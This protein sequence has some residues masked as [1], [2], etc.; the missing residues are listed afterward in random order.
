PLD[1]PNPLFLE[2][3]MRKV[4]KLINENKELKYEIERAFSE[5]NIL[6]SRQIETYVYEGLNNL[7]RMNMLNERSFEMLRGRV[8]KIFRKEERIQTP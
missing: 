8:E 7:L 1:M 4:E 2:A 6:D 3:L 5:K